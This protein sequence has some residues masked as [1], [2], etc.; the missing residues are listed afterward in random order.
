MATRE[1]CGI[2]T[3]NGYHISASGTWLSVRGSRFACRPVFEQPS[4]VALFEP[5]ESGNSFTSPV[6]SVS[7]RFKALGRTHMRARRGEYIE[8]QRYGNVMS[9]RASLF[10][11]ARRL[12]ERRRFAS[13]LRAVA[14]A[15][16]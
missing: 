16:A 13:C 7:N 12:T 8:S 9:V 4:G 1:P 14:R 15:S 5:V 11:T 3:T 10:L 2:T 6:T